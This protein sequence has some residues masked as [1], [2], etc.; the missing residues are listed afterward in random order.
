M[1][2]LSRFLLL[3]KLEFVKLQ[4]IK[5]LKVI[6]HC[7]TNSTSDFCRNCG[8][9]TSQVH[10]RRLVK[11]KDSPHGSKEKV[12]YITKK[13][14]RCTGCKSVFTEQIDGIFKGARLTQR[15]Q[16]NL[17]YCCDKFAN[18]KSVEKHFDLG[19]KTVYKRHY[20]QLELVWRERKNDPW[21]KSIGIDEH[22]FIKNKKYGHR[23]F[24]SMIVDHNNKRLKELVPGRTQ[25]QLMASLAYIPG[26]E[27]VKNVT[28]DMSPAYRSF[29]EE[30]FPKAKITADK[31]HVVRLAMPIVNKYRKEV[32]GDN[33]KLGIR[34]LL[35]KS[36]FDL[37]PFIRFEISKWLEDK[38]K[39]REA[40]LVKE[41]ILKM[42]RC[43]G[44]AK[45]ARVLGKLTDY[46]AITKIPELKKLRKTLMKW[47]N[48]ILNYFE[49]RLTNARVEGFNN[50]AKQVQKRAY[51]FKSFKNYRLKLLYACK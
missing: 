47:R 4:Q 40:Y 14:F 46:L 27:R 32:T 33:R 51:G 25:A 26:R 12:L 38:D 7:K 41:T 30:F 36:A 35:L 43:K 34:K 9:E 8:L 18:L 31:F 3:P 23:E 5:A 45:A 50:V 13:R 20:D 2:D 39:L 29:A 16:R 28:M 42:Y 17:L 19:S 21:P 15:L 1:N 22:S 37:D 11:I 48:E 44:R 6:F 49:T 10:D 24:V